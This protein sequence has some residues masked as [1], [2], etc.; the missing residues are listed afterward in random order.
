MFQELLVK[1]IYNVLVF[2]ADKIPG[3]NLGISVMILVLA[4][5]FLL[6]PLFNKAVQSQVL[7]KKIQ[8]EMERIRKVHKDDQAKQAQALMT[9][10]RE[11]HFNPFSSLLTIFIQLPILFALYQVFLRGA[12][13]IDPA[14]LYPGMTRLTNFQTLFLGVFELAK[15]NLF[16]ALLAAVVQGVASYFMAKDSKDVSGKMLLIISPVI[17]LVIVAPLPSVVAWYWSLTTVFSIIQQLI[18]ERK[19]GRNNAKT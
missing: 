11:N 7:M 18:I 3:N 8:P 16:L 13:S 2:I 15:P 6:W 5:R 4:I 9:L 19:Y 12:E 14:W 17:T 10:Y 1:P